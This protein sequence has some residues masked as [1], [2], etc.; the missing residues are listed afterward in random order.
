MLWDY[1]FSLLPEVV[2]SCVKNKPDNISGFMHAYKQ[3]S[4]WLSFLC[5][6]T[7]RI[8][9]L[10]DVN[11]TYRCWYGPLS[12][13]RRLKSRQVLLWHNKTITKKSLSSLH[14][15]QPTKIYVA[16]P[17][18]VGIIPIKKLCREISMI[19]VYETTCK[20]LKDG[21]F[22]FCSDSTFAPDAKFCRHIVPDMIKNLQ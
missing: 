8:T 1:F 22:K 9:S 12:S 20:V 19:K 13:E 15:Y 10:F 17:H 4:D 16:Q 21:R 18:K 7:S 5:F 14:S 3:N 6:I 11:N 2:L